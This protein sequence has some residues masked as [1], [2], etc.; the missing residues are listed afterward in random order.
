[1]QGKGCATE[2]TAA[3]IGPDRPRAIMPCVKWHAA[4]TLTFFFFFLGGGGGGV[5]IADF[6]TVAHV[7][8][9]S[10]HARLLCYPTELRL[11]PHFVFITPLIP[12][13]ALESPGGDPVRWTGLQAFNK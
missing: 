13:S 8:A 1:M 10:M 9:V 2:P 3:D 7:V 4:F 6:V 5:M 11:K 12:M